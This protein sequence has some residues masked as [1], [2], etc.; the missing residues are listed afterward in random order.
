[1]DS[2][3]A[4]L[5]SSFGPQEIAS[6]PTTY[7]SLG[8]LLLAATVTNIS[9]RVLQ[10][11]VPYSNYNQSIPRDTARLGGYS[12]NWGDAS[13]ATQTTVMKKI[14][15]ASIDLQPED[16]AILLGIA[17]LES[18][19][20][21]DAAATATSAS[22]VFQFIKSTGYAL[23]LTKETVFDADANIQAGIRLYRSNLKTVQNK[24]PNL[25][26]NERA[27]KLYAL[28][29]DGPSLKSGGAEIA[30]EKLLPYLEKFRTIASL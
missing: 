14:V 8:E 25:S 29:H 4:L 19:F 15:D 27:V 7:G 1:M 16:R 5:H 20:N 6:T 26:P 21:P 3:P 9:K 17:R 12:R 10:Q 22:G 13:T 24:Y 11:T 30:R 23:G 18:G 2:L 28:H